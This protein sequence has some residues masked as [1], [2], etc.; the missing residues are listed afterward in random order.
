[1]NAT[2]CVSYP[3]G[4]ITWHNGGFDVMHRTSAPLRCE[5]LTDYQS[6]VGYPAQHLSGE[7]AIQ[8]L[9]PDG[10]MGLNPQLVSYNADNEVLQLTL[11]D[12]RYP[13]IEIRIAAQLSEEGVYTQQV[14]IINGTGAPLQIIRGYSAS[15]QAHAH[16]YH[17]TTF[18][19]VW[20][21][22]HMLQE[23]EVKRGNTLSVQASTGIKAA[24]E[25]I[26]AM[27]LSLDA[28]AQE[29]IGTC[30]LASLYW[31]GNYTIS[32]THNAQ[33]IGFLGMGHDFAQAP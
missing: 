19:G 3:Y 27:L 12:T 22:E 5:Y 18:R 31:S 32:F 2:P 13:D 7:Y 20:A 33:G 26:P 29:E 14:S 23:E 17:A 30:L 9:L 1:M 16:C 6:R 11:S 28:P 8:L 25:G 4:S 10:S 15:M 24:Q 21:G